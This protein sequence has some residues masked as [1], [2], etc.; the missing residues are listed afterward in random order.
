MKY[1]LHKDHPTY[2]GMCMQCFCDVTDIQHDE[3]LTLTNGSK[4]VECPNPDCNSKYVWV[5]E[6]PEI[7]NKKRVEGP[8]G[9]IRK[10]TLDT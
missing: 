2:C 9:D 6:E 5:A 4:H 1:K 8:F 7:R 10:H 3:V